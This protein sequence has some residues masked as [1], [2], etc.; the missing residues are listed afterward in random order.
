MT[1]LCRLS[2]INK[3]QFY[4]VLLCPHIQLLAAK[5]SAVVNL[6]QISLEQ[7]SS[8]QPAHSLGCGD[9]V[10]RHGVSG[11]SQVGFVFG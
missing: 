6:G 8:A 9:A 11:Y 1:V 2:R 7:L 10:N 4:S 5:L 3:V